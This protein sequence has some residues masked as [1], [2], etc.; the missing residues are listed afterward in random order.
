ML[1]AAPA[2]YGQEQT[3]TIII[4]E[5]L[6]QTLSHKTESSPE[7]NSVPFTDIFNGIG[8]NLLCGFSYGYGLPWITAVGGTYVMVESGADWKWNRFAYN[9]KAVAFAGIPSGVVGALVPF[10]VPLSLYFYGESRQNSD[11]QITGLALGQA[12]M[13]GFGTS[14]AI[15]A[16]TGREAP[17]IMAKHITGKEGKTEDYSREWKFGFMRGGVFNGWPSSHTATAVAMSAA[18]VELYPNNTNVKIGAWA[19]AAFIGLGMSVTAHWAS[20]I[21]AGALIGYAIGSSVGKNFYALKNGQ[22]ES[23]VSFYPIP[24]GLMISVVF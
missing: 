1:I 6:P 4:S 7:F 12:A 13:L 19:Y 8:W 3:K 23:A 10:A 17:D 15:K 24:G 11:L 16:F 5:E 20:D 22:K 14:T 18:L 9:H 2:V 21:W